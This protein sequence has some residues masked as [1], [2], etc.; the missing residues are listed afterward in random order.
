MITSENDGKYCMRNGMPNETVISVLEKEL[1]IYKKALELLAK[2]YC[3]D[4]GCAY[5]THRAKCIETNHFEDLAGKDFLE[6]M[7]I[8]KAREE[9]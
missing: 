9:K 8:T 5:C 2:D 6:K 3:E 4:M 7:F 1:E